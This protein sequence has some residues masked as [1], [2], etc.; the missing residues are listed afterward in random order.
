MGFRFHRSFSSLH[1]LSIFTRG[2]HIHGG[3]RL[4]ILKGFRGAGLQGLLA[5]LC[6]CVCLC[7]CVSVCVSVCVCVSACVCVCVCLCVCV[8]VRV[9]VCVCLCVCVSVC[10]CVCLCVCVSVSVCV[11]VCLRVCVDLCYQEDTGFLQQPSTSA[12][13]TCENFEHV[14]LHSCK[15]PEGTSY[16]SG[17]RSSV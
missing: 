5:H 3:V 7:V 6:V 2:L 17:Q 14:L 8:C 4:T 11:C 15:G 12:D 16:S 9:C 1:K 13:R 10:V